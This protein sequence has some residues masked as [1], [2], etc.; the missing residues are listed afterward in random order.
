MLIN[1]NPVRWNPS[2]FYLMTVFICIIMFTPVSLAS[3]ARADFVGVDQCKACHLPEY[4]QWKD[5]DHDWAMRVADETSV[6]GDFNN[7][8]FEHFGSKTRF[9][10]RDDAWLV[11]TENSEGQL[12]EFTIS[13]TFG[14]FPLQQYLIG[15]PDGRYQALSVAWD[16]RPREAGGQRWFHLYPDEQISHQD[17]LHWTGTYFNWNSR[18]AACHS[19][20]LE[21]HYNAAENTYQTTWSEINVSCEACHGPG[22]NHV[23]WAEKTPH[24]KIPYGGFVASLSPVGEWLKTKDG[25]TAA[26]Q[27]KSNEAQVA[28]CGSCH[29]R[30]V[31]LTEPM[32]AGAAATDFHNHFQL[33][34]LDEALYHPDGQIK[35]E[36]FEMGSFMQS[37]MFH[38]GVVCSNCHD[39]HSLKLRYPGNQV[40]TQCHVPAVF[41]TPD[42]HHHPADSTGAQCANCH[43]PKTT[44]MVIDDRADH[45]IRIPR[46]DLSE[47]TGAP[48]VCTGCHQQQSGQWAATAVQSWLEASGKTLQKHYSET[49]AAAHAGSESAEAIVDLVN[50]M[51]TPAIVRAS[52][53]PLLPQTAIGAEVVQRQLNSED[54]L[55]RTRA[56][57]QF[58][59]WPSH[60]RTEYLLPLLNDKAKIVRLETARVLADINPQSLADPLGVQLENAFSEYIETQQVNADTHEA[61]INMGVFYSL[62]GLYNEAQKS[63]RQAIKL[64]PG[65]PIPYINS[66]DLYREMNDESKAESTLR[67]GLAKSSRT[68]QLHYALGLSLVRQKRYDDALLAL[69]EAS[70]L[71][72]AD[73]TY[74]R[75]YAVLLDHLGKTG[76][77]V[78][79]LEAFTQEH[80][81]SQTIIDLHAQLVLKTEKQ[82]ALAP[83]PLPSAPAPSE[84]APAIGWWVPVAGLLIVFTLLMGVLFRGRRSEKGKRPGRKKASGRKKG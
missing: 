29:A 11:E 54:A 4:Q 70:L 2:E 79:V 38:Q 61:H 41:D 55:V 58:E 19:T 73:E 17:V 67:S 57:G 84:P 9:Y 75:I 16:S 8:A 31:Q 56:V 44:Y 37:K 51:D 18:C 76:E 33:A 74:L 60:I 46:P 43:M 48:D 45:S 80:Q 68:A 47:K 30:R 1:N 13:Y 23:L 83:E 59:S 78:D 49:T 71:E 62:R 64:T 3:S 69:E 42:H 35:D 26:H 77:A 63:Y 20:H 52:A 6:L 65:F 72:P 82:S 15:F 40:C 50:S 53:M 10:R 39:P 36:V 81:A 22:K 21:R 14:F 66:A 5:S 34:L 25:S 28:A 32:P 7:T 12:Q 27:G 24:K